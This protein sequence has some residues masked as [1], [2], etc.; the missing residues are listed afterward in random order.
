[1]AKNMRS[2]SSPSNDERRVGHTLRLEENM[3]KKLKHTLIDQGETF[4]A[5]GERLIR[6][7]VESRTGAR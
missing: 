5:V 3:A 4:Q 2:A 6:E 1:M 7:Y